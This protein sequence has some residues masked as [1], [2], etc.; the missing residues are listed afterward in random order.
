LVIT[1]LSPPRLT[2]GELSPYDVNFKLNAIPFS[3]L[4]YANP[5]E[6]FE[7]ILNS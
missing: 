5:R 3:S 6:V 1:P 7:A 4:S 2:E